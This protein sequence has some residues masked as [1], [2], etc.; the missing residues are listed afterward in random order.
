MGRVRPSSRSS[1]PDAHRLSVGFALLQGVPVAGR[2]EYACEV[3]IS[4]IGG[5]IGSIV[6]QGPEKVPLLH[7]RDQ[8]VDPSAPTS[9]SYQR[10]RRLGY[11][12][13]PADVVALLCIQSAKSGGLSSIVRSIEVHDEIVRVRPD[14]AEVLYQP[15]WQ[16]RRSGDG[17]DS[18]FQSPVYTVNSRGRLSVSYGPDSIRSAQRGARVPPLSPAQLEAMEVLDRLNGDPRFVLTMDLRA[19]DMQFL[20][21]HVILHSRTEY[22]DYPEHRRRRDLIRLWLNTCRNSA[23]LRAPPGG[24]AEQALPAASL[25]C[26][27]SAQRPAE[28]YPHRRGRPGESRPGREGFRRYGAAPRCTRGVIRRGQVAPPGRGWSQ[29]HAAGVTGEIVAAPGLGEHE[30]GLA[31]LDP[32]AVR[33]QGSVLAGQS[34]RRVGRSRGNGGGTS[35]TSWLMRRCVVLA[36]ESVDLS[37]AAMSAGRSQL[38]SLYFFH[39][40]EYQERRGGPA[41]Q[42]AGGRDGRDVDRG[43]R[44]CAQGAPRP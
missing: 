26:R 27:D 36:D 1:R 33:E 40:V 3:I 7:V 25:A 32:E 2:A 9:R 6:T 18:F 41:C 38:G 37:T 5:Y 10:N 15:W 43:C 4:G 17:P 30:T 8:G 35:S 14:L 42:G 21:N 24:H 28:P 44:D 29:R 12:A 16:D 31:A 20:N 13:D 22:E 34:V 19:G 11:H 23:T 39:G